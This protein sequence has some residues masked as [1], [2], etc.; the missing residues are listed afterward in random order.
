MI[1]LD[2]IIVNCDFSRLGVIPNFA[3]A[4]RYLTTMSAGKFFWLKLGLFVF[5]K[6]YRT[7]IDGI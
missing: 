1:R 7:Y 4:L 3:K 6:I 5:M 2:A